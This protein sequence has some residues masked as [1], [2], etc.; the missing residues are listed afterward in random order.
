M[1]H[2]FRTLCSPI[3]NIFE[4]GTEAYNYKPLNRKILIIVGVLFAILTLAVIYLSPQGEAGVLIPV[5]V[6]GITGL[7]CLIVGA[8]GTDRAVAKIWGNK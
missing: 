2:F 6:F 7:I 5:S 1:K 4:S 3:L 8:L